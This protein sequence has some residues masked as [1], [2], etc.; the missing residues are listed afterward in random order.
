M[1]KYYL[2]EQY[3]M[4]FTTNNEYDFLDELNLIES[5]PQQ[6]LEY[7]NTAK[8]LI[9][10]RGKQKKQFNLSNWV[11]ILNNG[12]M[13]L[14][15]HKCILQLFE[16]LSFYGLQVDNLELILENACFINPYSHEQL[17]NLMKNGQI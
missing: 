16:E 13:S 2:A 1:Y 10:E 15:K 17:K 3:S 11:T 4:I 9:S 6:K 7:L 5:T 14:A 12:S 8:A